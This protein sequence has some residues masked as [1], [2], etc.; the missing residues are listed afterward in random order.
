[1]GVMQILL[2]IGATWQT[3]LALHKSMSP[4]ERHH[5]FGD[6]N[7]DKVPEYWVDKP[8]KTSHPEHDGHFL[9]N[10][11]YRGREEVFRLQKHSR[12]YGDEFHMITRD[13]NASAL[14]FSLADQECT[15]QGESI[16][17][18][19]VK[20]ALVGCGDRMHGMILSTLDETPFLIQPHSR[21][22]E[23]IIHKR[24]IDSVLHK[25]SCLFNPLDDPYP[26]DRL[27]ISRRSVLFSGLH[28]DRLAV[29][30]EED[31]TI[32]L[33]VFAD[34][35]M[36]RHFVDLYGGHADAEMHRFIL[37][38]VNNIDIL[39]GQ[40]VINPSVNIKI[41]RYEVI[42]T[43]P[44]TL[45]KA[46]H[47][48]GDV[49]RLL[50]AFCDYQAK[51][52]PQ[53]DEDPK[54]WDHALLF[55]GYD[56][57]RDGLKTV[58]GYA[59]VKG[60]CSETRSCTINEGLDFGSVFV[61]THEMGH[62]LGMYHDGDNECDLR[63]CI[64]SPSVGT[65][66]TQWSSCSVKEFSV[67]VTK[68]GTPARAPN[69]LRDLPTPGEADKAF[70]KDRESPGQQFTLGEQCAVFHGECWKHELRDGQ[71][72]DEVCEMVWCG[73]GEGIIRTA[74]PALE[75]TNC[76][77]NLWCRNGQ[78]VPATRGL[79]QIDG[80]WGTWNESPS[81]CRAKCSD[82][83]I[84]GQLQLRRST[85]L[86]NRPAA[87]NGGRECVGDDARGIVCDSRPCVGQS[88]D[89]F[90]S[91]TCA[92]LKND[93]DNPN[94]QLSGVGLQFEQAP[95]KIWCQ[96]EL[97]NNIR[98]VS[99][100]PD[101]T[102]CGDGNFCIK[103]ECRPLLCN[104]NAVAETENDCPYGVRYRVP[105]TPQTTTQP[106]TTRPP[107]RSTFRPTQQGR[108]I[109]NLQRFMNTQGNLPA[110]RRLQLT[111]RQPPRPTTRPT[112]RIEGSTTV[113]RFF[114]P[115]MPSPTRRPPMW[116]LWSEW[117]ECLTVGCGEKGIKVRIRRCVGDQNE[118]IRDD[119]CR[120]HNRETARCMGQPCHHV[121]RRMPREMPEENPSTA[122][123]TPALTTP[124]STT[125]TSSTVRT[126]EKEETTTTSPPP[127]HDEDESLVIELQDD[128]QEVSMTTSSMV[129]P[130]PPTT[131][132]NPKLAQLLPKGS[133]VR[134]T[135]T[136]E[137]SLVEGDEEY[138]E[139]PS[140]NREEFVRRSSVKRE[141][142]RGIDEDIPSKISG[143][144]SQSD[145]VVDVPAPSLERANGG[146][147]EST[148]GDGF[149]LQERYIGSE[150]D[151]ID[152][153]EPRSNRG[154]RRIKDWEDDERYSL[155]NAKYP[156]LIDVP[157]NDYRVRN[158]PIRQFVPDPLN[159]LLM[160][161]RNVAIRQLLPF[162]ASGSLETLPGPNQPLN[163]VQI[164]PHDP[165]DPL[166]LRGGIE[167]LAALFKPLFPNQVPLPT[168]L[169]VSTLPEGL[170]P[171]AP[172]PPPPP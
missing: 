132:I 81:S 159:P 17:D 46:E 106:P 65:G 163:P 31:L 14:E 104:G 121:T 40:R 63:C 66:K 61:V 120:G 73:N 33:A 133:V 11:S 160:R 7:V 23:H 26:E 124:S 150:D 157:A 145:E 90:A 110:A 105:S 16:D 76:G 8:R 5:I 54:H 6:G 149:Q 10:I 42:K 22:D 112:H 102:P 60:M 127:H 55:S 77:P 78:C 128:V 155:K 170:I 172:P 156:E 93:P 95:C 168:P 115:T 141:G 29:M 171:I 51:L 131:T 151:V 50:D 138:L 47:K 53:G 152:V 86:C 45:T 67:F 1:M 3:T 87:N 98:T 12:L 103:G 64:M 117:S 119:T 153:P 136:T 111:T 4:K 75:G 79:P 107:L 101:G 89:N 166:N 41:V 52:N 59:P 122:S 19:S 100:F 56:L 84:S 126:T 123:F 69:C 24:S 30:K 48:Y 162:T 135:T 13:A 94:P 165:S 68:L 44:A 129:P 49:D 39:Y 2:V 70:F 167:N 130:P 35:A 82:C 38:A 83:E 27:P 91:W 58:A 142:K 9:Y 161:Q 148:S 96:L 164:N 36:W 71:A 113:A 20:I 143:E 137:E 88:V 57:Y 147:Y 97:S 169:E 134:T 158:V 109:S 37:A 108:R 99:N 25:H 34:D 43:P 62:S 92:K 28:S 114:M 154:G 118:Y 80:Q 18:P 146:K 85:R 140:E 74:H 72:L 125:M 144:S 21:G 116:S 139:P 15:Y 32:E